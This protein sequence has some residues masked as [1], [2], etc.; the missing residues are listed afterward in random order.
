[1]DRE[2]YIDMLFVHPSHGRCGVATVLLNWVL[3]EAARSGAPSLTT[4]A[5]ITARPFFEAND[6]VVVEER[7]PITRGVILQN[8]AMH[9]PI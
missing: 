9:R 3:E 1:M 2:G 7:H 8:Y 6:F 5:S 4:H